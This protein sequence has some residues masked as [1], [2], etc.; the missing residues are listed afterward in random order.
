MGSR[1]VGDPAGETCSGGK[2]IVQPMGSRADIGERV[3]QQFIMRYWEQPEVWGEELNELDRVRIPRTLAM[4]PD[5][6]RTILEV[7]CGN[8]RLSNRV[9]P[10]FKV[11]GMDVSRTAVRFVKTNKVIGDSHRVPL[12]D[13]SVDLVIC[14]DVLE[15]LPDDILMMTVRELQRVARR[16]LLIGVPYKEPYRAASFECSACGRVS[17][18]F[19]HLRSFDCGSLDRL[20]PGCTL[21]TT[22]FVG[23]PRP[24]VNQA[25]LWGQQRLGRAYWVGGWKAVCPACGHTQHE[26]LPRTVLQKIIGKA[27]YLANEMLDWLI[28]ASFKP[29]HEI[30]RLY[31]ITPSS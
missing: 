17:N 14:A 26:P 25:L 3:D 24:Y 19:G 23:G 20:F 15:H 29:E 16:Y 18:K 5:R 31:E 22:A 21:V 11:I 27:C 10:R 6:V 8:G 4:I 7:G 13:R 12:A 28:P 9:P 1:P 30:I 2:V